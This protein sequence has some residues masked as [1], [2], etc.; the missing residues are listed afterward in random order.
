[1][2]SVDQEPAIDVH[3]LDWVDTFT[4]YRSELIRIMMRLGIL[5]KNVDMDALLAEAEKDFPQRARKGSGTL[6]C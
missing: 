1:M 2:L 6:I 3:L 5:P 4:T